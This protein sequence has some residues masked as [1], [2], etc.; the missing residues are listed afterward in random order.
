MFGCL[1]VLG[2]CALVS[3]S[4]LSRRQYLVVVVERG[5]EDDANNTSV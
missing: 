1:S 4:L 5:G 3:V 2:C